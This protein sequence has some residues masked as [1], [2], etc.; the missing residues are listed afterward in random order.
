MSVRK[1]IR[2][3]RRLSL[4]AFAS[5]AAAS[6]FGMIGSGAFGSSVSSAAFSGGSGTVSVGGT[7]YSKTGGALTLTVTT[8]SDT[9]CIDVTGAHTAHQTSDTAK[10]TWTFSFTPGAGNGVQT[11]T[12]A[13][14]PDF[15]KNGACTGQKGAGQAS[16]VLDNTGPQVTAAL[17]PVANAAGWSNSNVGI[18]WSATDADSGVAG[19]PT[20]A[21][22]SVT[23]NTAGTTK[24]ATATDRLGNQ[25]SGAVTV[26]LDKTSPTISTTRSPQPNADGWNN[27]DVT[28]GI[29]CDD[30]LSGIKSCTGGGTKV[31]SAEGANQSLTASAVDN[32]DNTM[33]TTVG[34]I[35][36]DKT[37]PS[38]TGAVADGMLGDNGW[39][40]GNVTIH[41]T[42]T[43]ALSGV[44]NAPADSTIAGEGQNLKATASVSDKAGNQR[45]ADSPAVKIDK[46]APNTDAS[47]VDA[48]N[49]VDVTVKLTANDALSGVAATHYRIDGGDAQN[50]TQVPLS[51]EG[52]HSLEY[53]SVDQAGNAE[54]H[55]TVTVRIDKSSPT[56]SHAFA[57]I[58]NANGWFKDDVH[59][60]FSCVDA[61]SGVKSCGPDRVVSSEGKDQDAS[62]EAVDNAGNTALDPAAVSLDRTPPTIK[63]SVDRDAN[64]NGWYDD[65]VT[66][67]FACGDALSGVDTCPAAKTLGEGKDQSASATVADAAGNTA[68]DGVTGVDVDKTAPSLHGA[69]KDQP[70]DNGWYRGDVVVAWSCSDELSGL[71]GDCPADSTI[72]GEGSNLSASAS[73]KDKA[74]NATNGK[75]DGIGIDRTAPTTSVE[76]AEPL[77]S[78]WYADAVKVTLKGLDSLSGVDHTYYTVDGG[79]PQVYAGAF[80]FGQKGTHTIA[81]WSVDKAGNVEDRTAPGHSLT[82]QIDG[83]APSIEGHRTPAAN[84]FGWSNAPVTVTFD[85]ADA[86]S[87]IAGC[88]GPVTLENEGAG[89]SVHGT[90]TDNAGNHAS[91]QVDDV[92]IDLTAPTLGGAPTTDANAAG[93]YR[94]DVAIHWTAADALSGIDPGSVPADSVIDGEGSDLGAGPV[95]VLD[96]AGNSTSA[97]VHGIKIDRTAPV[98]AGAPTT[99]PNSYGWYGGDVVVAFSCTDNLSGVASCPSDKLISANGADQSVT[100][101][102][103]T[104]V[105]GNSAGGRTV[106]GLNIDGLPPQTTADNQCTRSNGWCTGSS[107]TVVLTATDQA[108]LSGVKEIH[109]R[110][111]GGDEQVAAGATKSVNVA[112]DGSG[113]A[114]V[115]FYAVDKAGNREAGNGVALKYDNIAP[116]VTHT[117]DPTANADGWNKADVTVHFDAK[118]N[119][120]GSGVD[121]GRTTPDVLVSAETA[122]R[123]VDGEAYDLAGNRG[124]D[125]AMVRLDKTAPAISAA[126][127]SGQRGAGGWYVGPVKV[128]F[129][130]SDELSKVAVCP[131]DVTLT[132]NGAGQSVSGEAV[133][134]AGNR[135]TATVTG[136]DIDQEKPAITVSGIANGATYTLGAVPAASCSAKDG[137]SGA[138]SCAVTVTGGKANGVGQ[139]AY[140]AT[141][142][143]KAG[144]TT[145]QTGSYNVVYRFDGFLQ[146]INDTAHQI[147]AATS[148][149]KAG[150]TVPVKLQL[151]RADGT[152][153]QAGSAPIWEVPAKGSPTTAPVDESVYT[154]AGDS[155]AAYRWDGTDQQYIYNWG[156]DAAGKGY[157]HRIGVRLDDGQTYFVNIGL[158]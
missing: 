68:S 156:T 81:F 59:V 56:I 102:P 25:G 137:V 90:A 21:S 32:A 135:A 8:S 122:G 115:L 111:N 99:Q 13:P 70:N 38:L 85:C 54:A 148:I 124:A 34:P 31:V 138:D 131:D 133:D 53:W 44:T 41:W 80:D 69:A 113:E 78:G 152:K 67:S 92:N 52:V 100:S 155:A 127:V 77:A 15:N 74:G 30:T 107:A 105:A 60:T 125:S 128:H 76:V 153:V 136:I 98:I 20:P 46:T 129:T 27:G 93:W 140:T 147:G 95:S 75:V 16:Y 79:D 6:L 119:D 71:A 5:I 48:W 22:D 3:H 55:K 88:D 62:G 50:G 145:T 106:G 94:G 12:A 37:A 132:A 150:S 35:N 139:F 11:V 114:S 116:L 151:K 87:G 130:C 101:D 72:T 47:A 143:D 126:I 63:A 10:S 97:S 33:S 65:D 2:R 49:N 117:L 40:R 83:I 154:V 19:A 103:A 7:L 144:N 108:G 123:A 24:T 112:L 18:T 86:E 96:K 158:R 1:W 23:T 64:G 58:A 84:A 45:V 141:A 91:A 39:Y 104:D 43:D 57:P 51:D 9:K 61:L 29:T 42:A 66:V 146:P 82:I 36:I 26:K 142:K 73:V 89:Q 157:Y 110:V 121:A 149:F 28:V 17:S 134:F 109:Y 4:L 120:G 118:D 14:S